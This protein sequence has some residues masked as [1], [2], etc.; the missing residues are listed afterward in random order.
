MIALELYQRWSVEAGGRALKGFR[1]QER[2]E[3]A[4][5]KKPQ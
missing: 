2:R 1:P 5:G 3:E 4:S